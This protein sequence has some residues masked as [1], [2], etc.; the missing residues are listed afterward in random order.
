[1]FFLGRDS[2][3]TFSLAG[4]GVKSSLKGPFKLEGEQ[5]LH[6]LSSPASVML[7]YGILSPYLFSVA[8]FFLPF[9]IRSVIK[10]Y[11][12]C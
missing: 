8:S 7:S 5:F 12:P 10:Q 11:K 2:V 3:Y 9:Q 1:V 4:R 6:W